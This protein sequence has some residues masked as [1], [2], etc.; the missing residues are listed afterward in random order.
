MYRRTEA[1]V[2]V[3]HIESHLGHIC[4]DKKKKK[5]SDNNITSVDA[6]SDEIYI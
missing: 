5:V 4:E 1:H 3:E 6:N 2:Y